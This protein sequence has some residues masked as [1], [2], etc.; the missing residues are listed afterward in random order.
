MKSTTLQLRPRDK[1]TF[2]RFHVG[3]NY[4]LQER[5]RSNQNVWLHGSPSVG[6]THLANALLNEVPHTLLIDDP[7]YELAG[8]DRFELIIFDDIEQ[9]LGK[10]DS[11]LQLLTLYE[12]LQASEGRMVA[13]ARTSVNEQ[14]IGIR[15]LKSR[16]RAF[17][18]I[19]VKPLPEE[20]KTDLLIALAKERGIALSQEVVDYMLKRIGRTQHDLLQALEVLDDTSIVEQRPVTIPFAKKALQL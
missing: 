17:H 4:N 2:E 5:L 8:S 20:Q 15:D 16:M 12:Q 18:Q 1:F 3:L 19:C 11:E 9:W 13:T 7:S 6:K 10:K 14:V